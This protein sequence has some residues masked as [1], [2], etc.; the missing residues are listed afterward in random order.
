MAEEKVALKGEKILTLVRKPD[1]RLVPHID[2]EP[3]MGWVDTTTNSNGSQQLTQLVFHSSLV[4]FETE[5]NPY[6]GKMN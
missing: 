2:G 4:L 6:A 3:I 5:K 1:G